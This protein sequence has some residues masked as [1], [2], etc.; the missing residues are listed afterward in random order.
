MKFDEN[1]FQLKHICGSIVT[2][3]GSR[4]TQQCEDKNGDMRDKLDELSLPFLYFYF[5]L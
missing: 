3:N 1:F 2:R 4:K 5:I